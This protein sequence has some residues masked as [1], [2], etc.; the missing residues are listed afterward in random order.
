M[1]RSRKP[2]AALFGCAMLLSC[3][4]LASGQEK[5]LT[6]QSRGERVITQ[7]PE[8][9]P[10]ENVIFAGSEMGLSFD[11]K[12]VK[13]APYSAQ[14]ITETTQILGDGNRI[15]NQNKASVYRD[16]EGRTRR[17]E[18]IAAIG[19]M[20]SG[21]MPQAIFI[22]DPVAGMSYM[23]EPNLHVAHKMTPML[24]E[25]KV[26]AEGNKPRENSES[27]PGDPPETFTVQVA[28]P[29]GAEIKTGVAISTQKRSTAE[30]LGKQNIE[31]IEAEGTRTTTTIPAGEIGNERAIEIVSERWYSPELQTVVMTKHSDPRFGETVYRLTNIS[32]GEPDKNLFQ[33]PSDYKLKES[34][35]LLAAPLP[36]RVR[37]PEEQ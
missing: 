29:A 5:K 12:L 14:A 2:L 11:G 6:I 18:A 28:P 36:M 21:Q 3:A 15:V 10:L 30:S 1:S 4:A 9:E 37:R 31:G 23:L 7:G 19:P 25:F 22:N 13:D 24:F 34:P 32:R 16:S 33:V 17:E 27:L 35:P 20:A 8:T 26:E